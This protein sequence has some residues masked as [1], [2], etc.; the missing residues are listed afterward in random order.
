M[1][2]AW[3]MHPISLGIV[4][5]CNIGVVFIFNLSEN[6]IFG[7]Q[8]GVYS[9]N[10]KIYTVF[11]FII[12]CI[13]KLIKCTEIISQWLGDSTHLSSEVAV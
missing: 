13:N 7:I 1:S 10:R 12:R 3:L 5:D 6:I 11:L 9:F 2:I 8:C 4:A